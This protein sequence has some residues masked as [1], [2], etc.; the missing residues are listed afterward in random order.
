M[1]VI[2]KSQKKGLITVKHYCSAF[3]KWPEDG[4][5]K[6]SLAKS[7]I[8]GLVIITEGQLQPDLSRYPHYFAKNVGLAVPTRG[9]LNRNF[10]N[11]TYMVLR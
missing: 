6:K 1:F 9:Q 5:A 4:C 8:V 7:S 3:T 11:F 10:E 2:I